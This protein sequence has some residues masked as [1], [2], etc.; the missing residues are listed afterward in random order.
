M[1]SQ[2]PTPVVTYVLIAL[3]VLIFAITALQAK[4]L[5][6]NGGGVVN[7]FTGVAT[8]DS[9]LFGWMVLDSSAVAQGELF[10]VIGSGFLH[11]GLIHWP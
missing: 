4:S 11:F 5:M 8:F 10:R 6:D 1:R 7:R 9:P 3:N 2:L